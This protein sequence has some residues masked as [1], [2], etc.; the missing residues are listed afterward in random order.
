[1]RKVF[2]SV[3]DI[4]A[5][6]YVYEIFKEGFED[7]SLVG[8]TDHRLES[9]G[10]RSVASV[11]ELSVVGLVEVLPRL[12]SIKRT[13]SRVLKE[14]K[15]CDALIACDAPGFNLRLIREARKIG[16]GKIIYFISPQVWAWK[17]KRAK[18]I[19]DFADHMVVILPFEVDIYRKFENLKV[20][21]VG[22]PLV[23]IAKPSLNKEDFLRTLR[24]EEPFVAL[25]PGSRWSE[26]KRHTP[27]LKEVIRRVSRE[28]KNISFVLP[29][30][31]IFK[32]FLLRELSELG[33]KVITEADMKNPAYNCMSYSAVSLVASG[34]ASLEA[35][36]LLNPHV[37][38]YRVNPLTLLLARRLVKVPYISLAN[39]I[40]G[41]KV[42]P[43]LINE[44]PRHITRELLRLMENGEGIKEKLAKLKLSLGEHGALERL[45]ELFKELLRF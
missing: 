17:P 16:V 21:Y 6:N 1:M 43:E 9:I 40:L 14:L 18:T 34:T 39:L 20:H 27:I 7:F 25:M 30:F 32:D 35:S 22:H 15:D 41:E 10:M 12:L 44:S 4:S 8:I 38:F 3:G 31:E 2:I 37:V 28:H 36:L 13:F 29:T 19:A 11:S 23:D 42:L 45:R 24:L 5:S 26:I 33:V